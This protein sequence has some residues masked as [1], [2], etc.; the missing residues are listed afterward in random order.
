MVHY[1]ENA[2]VLSIRP[3]DG[4]KATTIL[5]KTWVRDGVCRWENPVY[6][7]VKFTQDPKAG[8]IHDR[9]YYFVISTV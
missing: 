2:L 1:G 3:E 8:K 4:E 5:E 9:I 7:T 6:E